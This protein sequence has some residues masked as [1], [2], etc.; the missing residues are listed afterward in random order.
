MTL[1]LTG[2]MRG[3][4]DVPGLL[5]PGRSPAAAAVALLAAHARRPLHDANGPIP[6]DLVVRGALALLRGYPRPA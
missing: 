4:A 3:P 2:A 1:H 6:D 5:S